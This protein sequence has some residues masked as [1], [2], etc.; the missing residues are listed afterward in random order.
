MKNFLVAVLIH[1]EQYTG[2]ARSLFSGSIEISSVVEDQSG[3]G[4]SS[5]QTIEA[6]EHT[7]VARCVHFEDRAIVAA[8]AS[9]CAVEVTLGV[10][11]QRCLGKCSIRSSIKYVQYG[12]SL[13][14]S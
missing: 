10:L 3:I 9:S 12:E 5:I 2:A 7:L 6:E 4:E 13:R 1:P 14:C 8:A 11:N